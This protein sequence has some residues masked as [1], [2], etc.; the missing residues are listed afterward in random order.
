MKRIGIVLAISIALAIVASCAVMTSAEDIS[1]SDRKYSATT[2]FVS[3]DSST[4]QDTE[5]ATIPG[6]TT[7]VYNGTYKKDAV[8][9]NFTT[10]QI[11]T[12]L[13]SSVTILD[14]TMCKAVDED[15]NPIDRTSQF[16]TTDR[17]VILWYKAIVHTGDTFTERWYDPNGNLE[18]ERTRETSDLPWSSAESKSASHFYISGKPP[19]NKP[20]RWHVT[21][22]CNGVRKFTEYFTISAPKKPDLIITDIYE[23]DNEIYYKI[24]NQGTAN[25]GSSHSYLYI[26]GS[27]KAEDYVG[28]ISAGSTK[29][30]HFDFIWECSE[31]EDTIKVCADAKSEVTESR[32]TNNCREEK[33]SC[34]ET[35]VSVK[36]PL[37]VSEGENS[38]EPKAKVASTLNVSGV[39]IEDVD[40]PSLVNP[41]ESFNATVHTLYNFSRETEV[42]ILLYDYD[43][44]DQNDDYIDFKVGNLSGTGNKSFVFDGLAITKPKVV[45]LTAVAGYMNESGELVL[46]DVFLFPTVSLNFT[47]D[48][49]ELPSTVK[50]NEIFNVTIGA[51]Y[52][53]A[54]VTD[55]HLDIFDWNTENWI[56]R[57]SKTISGSDNQSFN[58]TLT[59]QPS[60]DMVLVLIAWFSYEFGNDTVRG[61]LG[62]RNFTVNVIKNPAGPVPPPTTIPTLPPTPIPTTTAPLPSPVVIPIDSWEN[63]QVELENQVHLSITVSI[64]GPS[65]VT[66]YLSP[67]DTKTKQLSPGEYSIYAAAT[68]V[69]PYSGSI[70]LS[71]GYKYI[72]QFYISQVP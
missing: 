16:Y 63:P 65:S 10:G 28:S 8:E 24:K 46:S 48:K 49:L 17:C 66:L 38:D 23:K 2:I 34:P 72:W 45:N 19:A 1:E 18:D 55:I 53:V 41:N 35:T 12:I 52:N 71:K 31:S 56:L 43:A 47:I 60:V 5:N 67:G 64:S 36:N 42:V 40:S 6:Y 20:G 21:L 58:L 69:I 13:S 50:S 14:H 15:N 32:G 27:K 26:D 51:T 59:A 37:K 57:Y 11:V 70:T 7:V 61:L 33:L 44:W 39:I 29:T 68:G 4:F 22:Y 54:P 9:K 30:E 3:D 25:A 62:H